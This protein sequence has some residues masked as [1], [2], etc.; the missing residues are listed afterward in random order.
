MI[1]KA[2]FNPS[3]TKDRIRDWTSRH[4]SG[5]KAKV[6]LA[7]VAFSEASFFLVP[8]DVVLIAI[9]VIVPARWF[10]YASLTTV[11]S[12]LG[13]MF[14]YVL[15]FFFFEAI[16]QWIITTYH[17]AEEMS[18]VSLLFGNNAFLAI[19]ISAFTPI[20]YKVFTITAGFFKINFLVFILASLLGRGL[21]FFFVGYLMNR[22]GPALGRT[23]YKYFNLFALGIAICLIMVILYFYLT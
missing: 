1:N 9:L 13:G 7:L 14:G 4:A 20:P 19:F 21:R 15:G 10:Y 2:L 23:M 18:Q 17:L 11:A 6:V 12:V 5:F 16:G 22:F 3:L 8:P